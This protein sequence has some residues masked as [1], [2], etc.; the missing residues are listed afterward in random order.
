MDNLKEKI[1]YQSRLPDSIKVEIKE[2]VDGGYF[3]K[4]LSLE[5]CFTQAD[6][7]EELLLMVNDMV[8]SYF[9]VPEKLRPLMPVYFPEGEI[10][11]KL[12]EWLKAIPVELLNLP[13]TYV[14]Q[15]VFASTQ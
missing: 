10:K 1:K 5:H 9:D 7:A 14:Q 2:S 11:R 4:I 15:G 13:L 8:Y 3:V 12:Q 6:D